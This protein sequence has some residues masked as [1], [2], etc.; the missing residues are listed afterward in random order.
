[1]YICI[2]ILIAALLLLRA[3]ME[4]R[5]FKKTESSF[6]LLHPPFTR[7]STPAA[8]FARLTVAFLPESKC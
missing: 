1:M 8:S 3:L 6:Y 2:Y 4:T 7:V 5:A